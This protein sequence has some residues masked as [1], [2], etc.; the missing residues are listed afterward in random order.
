MLL[1]LVNVFCGGDSTERFSTG[2]TYP[3]VAVPWGMNAWAPQAA[4]GMGTRWFYERR[5]SQGVGLCE[6][7][8]CT[9]QP[10]PWIRDYA[11]FTLLPMN[12][13]PSRWTAEMASSYR[14]DEEVG[15][16]D[17]YKVRLVRYG[18]TVEVTP[19]CRCAAV[20]MSFDDP[21]AARLLVMVPDGEIALRGGRLVG[22]TS[23]VDTQWHPTD[24]PEFRP[25][26]DDDDR[27]IRLHFVIETDVP[28]KQVTPQQGYRGHEYHD[29]VGAYAMFEAEG[30]VTLRIGTSFIS[31]GQA[32][33]N[34]RREVGGRSFEAIRAD[35]AAAWERELGRLRIDGG[36]DDQRRT[37]YT[38]LYRALLFPRTFHEPDENGDLRHYSPYS[39]QIEAGE[40]WT[41][42][43]FWDTHRTVYPLLA[44]AWPQT[45]ASMLRGF[46]NAYRQGGWL[47]R[48]CAPGYVACMV[49][50]HLAAVACDAMSRGIGGFDLPT[51]FEAMR[52]DA[53]VPSTDDPAVGRDLLAEYHALGFVPDDVGADSVART[54]DYVY[55][56]W[57]VARVA[58]HLGHA[59]DAA[60]FDGRSRGWRHLSRDGFLRPRNAD[61]TWADWR[62]FRWGGAYVEG[63]PWQYRFNVPHDAAGLAET[64][65]GP[66]ALVAEIERML[67]TP[68]TFEVGHY[69]TEIHEMTEMAAVNFGQYAHSNQ[70][71]HGVLW[72][73]A[74][75]GRP[76]VTDAAVRRVLA[77]LYHPD[78]ITGD[79]DNG[80]Q[81][82]W[83]VLA[84]CGLFPQCPG[85][86]R[87]V[88]TPPLWDRVRIEA[89]DGTVRTWT[90]LTPLGRHLPHDALPR[91]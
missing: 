9:H 76:D 64:F 48:W 44:L 27:D 60:L 55:N 73:P 40:M 58:E 51:L 13:P 46:T 32:E 70:P 14:H 88:T 80:E 30:P 56:D 87:W 18:V 77:E 65:G 37:F 34:L 84:S 67:V 47:P 7:I 20:R 38:M 54:L 25:G 81:G 31:R 6:G 26:D 42:N 74:L 83:Y 12:E 23:A 49:G 90:D 22:Y 57:N 36:T 45:L 35:A 66:A 62:E 19:T 53:T 71:V 1:D 86:G 17:Y 59:E 8:R 41:D 21:A 79:E 10:S 39:G 4:S 3:A 75:L 33:L 85:D 68:P 5:P 43:G 63:G 11:H 29:R 50:N 78:R 82:A 52:K 61:G 16:P 2:N 24:R 89:E 91:G 28:F 72:L 69:L 15:R